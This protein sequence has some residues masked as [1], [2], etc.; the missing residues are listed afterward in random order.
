LGKAVTKIKYLRLKL[1]R[2]SRFDTLKYEKVVSD[3]GCSACPWDA[4][5]SI[6]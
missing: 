6:V 1:R 5:S 4:N 3:L 2:R